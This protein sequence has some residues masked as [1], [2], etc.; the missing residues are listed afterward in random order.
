MIIYIINKLFRKK[1]FEITWMYYCKC[2]LSIW[3]NLILYPKDAFCQVW[4]KLAQW[5]YRRRFLI[6]RFF[7]IFSLEKDM[8]LHLNKFESPLPKNTLYQVWLK[9][10]HWI[11]KKEENVN[12][13][14]IDVQQAIRKAHLSFQ[15]RWA[16]NEEAIYY[17]ASFTPQ[18]TR[19]HHLLLFYLE[20]I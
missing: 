1:R 11:W 13:L 8:A 7:V 4:L 19:T 15:L 9:L 12:S 10:A 3:N 18:K 20:D 17:H 16:K 14:R 5:F 6:F 2:G